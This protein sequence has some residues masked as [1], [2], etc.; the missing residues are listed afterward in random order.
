MT[1]NCVFCGIV[2]GRLPARRVYEDEA[3]IA[4]FPL[5]HTQPGHTL[6]VPKRH[7]DYVFDLDDGAYHALWSVAK[8]LAPAI[9][10]VS[11]AARVG[12]AVEGFSV[13]HVH[14]HL[15]PINALN[16]LSPERARALPDREADTLAAALRSAIAEHAR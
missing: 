11:G 1:A 12:V 7:V 8:R 15:V 16:D 13:P 4:F 9:R 10:S 5:Q 6:L 3:H 2:A 14:L